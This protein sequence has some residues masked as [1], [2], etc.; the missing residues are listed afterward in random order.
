[1]SVASTD[2]NVS[3]FPP[4]ILP[5]KFTCASF[6]LYNWK[7][8]KRYMILTLWH[9]H[10]VQYLCYGILGCDTV[11]FGMWVKGEDRVVHEKAMKAN[12][13][14]GQFHTLTALCLYRL[15]SGLC[16]WVPTFQ[17][18][19]LLPSPG[20]ELG[21]TCK[22]WLHAV[23]TYK[24]A[25]FIS[26]NFIVIIR[27]WIWSYLDKCVVYNLKDCKDYTILTFNVS[28]IFRNAVYL[29]VSWPGSYLILFP[30]TGTDQG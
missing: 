15:N 3:Y 4:K 12:G 19:V 23:I 30:F 11:Q 2:T 16:R 6:I 24:A 27:N 17:R 25:T 21:G 26:C 28:A 20:K 18:N 14:T 1:V 5:N 8:C 29:F 10:S 9:F 22:I 7:E 13:M